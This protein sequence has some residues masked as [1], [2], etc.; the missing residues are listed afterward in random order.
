M[1]AQRPTNLS[2]AIHGIAE[3]L[4]L[5]DR[6]VDA[7]MAMITVHQWKNF[8]KGLNEMRRVTRNQIII[9]TFDGDALDR[10]WLADYAP[11]MIAFERRRFPKIDRICQLLGGKTE[12]Q[13]IPIPIDCVDGFNEAFYARP[14]Q[15][16][17]PTVRRSQSAWSFVDEK[18]QEQFVKNL[19]N[20]L[21]SG[22][23]DQRCGKW[24]TLP[25]FEG[26]LRLIVSHPEGR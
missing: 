16:L 18:V 7:S 4:P 11:Q 19:R 20:D 15:F 10:F 25:S 13:T 5:D 21:D 3:E 14:E 23:W 24:R 2:P 22:A 12:V 6:S 1:R 8:E 17:D 26:S 9:L